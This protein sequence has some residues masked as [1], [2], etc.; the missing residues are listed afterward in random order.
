MIE[1]AQIKN[2][3]LRINPYSIKDMADKMTRVASN[4]ALRAELRLKG[5][6]NIQRFY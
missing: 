6:L 5:H 4:P 3:Q 1:T 2:I